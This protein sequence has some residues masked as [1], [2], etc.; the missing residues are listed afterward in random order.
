MKKDRVDVKKIFET[1]WYW[2]IKIKVWKIFFDYVSSRKISYQNN[3]FQLGFKLGIIKKVLKILEEFF[4]KFY[5]S[6]TLV[7]G[8]Q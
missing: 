2:K 7:P 4:T 6:K 3:M 5:D 8:F 1:I